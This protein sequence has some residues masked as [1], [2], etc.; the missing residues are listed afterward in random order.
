MRLGLRRKGIGG[1]SCA[2]ACEQ[3]PGCASFQVHRQLLHCEL[4]P[5]PGSALWTELDPEWDIFDKECQQGAMA[6]TAPQTT[7]ASCA[8]VVDGQRADPAAYRLGLRYRWIGPVACADACVTTPGCMAIQV[9]RDL[10]HCELLT[11]SVAAL[12][13]HP[14][15]DWDIFDRCRALHLLSPPTTETVAAGQ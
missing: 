6:S 1:P 15:V 11:T 12:T 2:E 10:S 8:S 13:T 5:L 3:T 4:L 7:E 9:H 14:D